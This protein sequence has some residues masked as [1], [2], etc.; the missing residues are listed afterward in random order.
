M[1]GRGGVPPLLSSRR[2]E[3]TARDAKPGDAVPRFFAEPV[4]SEAEGLR[5]TGRDGLRTARA[6][7][8]IR[9]DPCYRHLA[10]SIRANRQKG[11]PLA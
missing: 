8:V 3:Q 10:R 6:S 7:K 11:K 4:L 1:G 9:L 2:A 5:V